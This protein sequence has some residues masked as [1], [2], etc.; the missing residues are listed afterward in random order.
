MKMLRQIKYMLNEK[1]SALGYVIA[2]KDVVPSFGHVVA[3]LRGANFIPL[4]VIDVGVAYGTPWLYEAFPKAKF[5]LVDP[6]RESRPYMEAWAK[7]IDAEI[8]NVGL[9]DRDAELSISVRPDHSGSSLFVEVGDCQISTT[10]NVPIRRFDK[11][12]HEFPRP[13]LCKVDVQGAELMV[14]RG[15][16]DRIYDIDVFVIETSLIATL[17]GAPEFA[18]IVDVMRDYGLA[19]YDIVGLNRR[20]LDRALAQIDAVFVREASPLRADRRW[21][22]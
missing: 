10:Y 12:F 6:T 1:L 17:E 21:D 9:G 19:L 18:E 14:L 16:G 15:M 13:S 22:A 5:H 7:K 4:T 11:I 8:Y 3:L 20:P 2:N